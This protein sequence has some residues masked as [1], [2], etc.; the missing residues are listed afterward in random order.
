MLLFKVEILLRNQ[1]EHSNSL[2]KPYLYSTKDSTFLIDPEPNK[3]TASTAVSNPIYNEVRVVPN[4]FK[5]NPVNPTHE[6]GFLKPKHKSTS[7]S[8]FKSSKSTCEIQ[9]ENLP[10]VLSSISKGF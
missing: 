6:L 2:R 5:S 1:V 4:E 3:S 7:N 9:E 10:T 8:V